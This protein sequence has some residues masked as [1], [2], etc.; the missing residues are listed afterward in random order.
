[1]VGVEV[2]RQP[3]VSG[4]QTGSHADELC[5]H[6]QPS[7]ILQPALKHMSPAQALKEWQQRKPELFQ[8]IFYKQAGLDK[9]PYF[10]NIFTRNFHYKSLS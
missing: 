5:E 2:C 3:T 9:Q 10:L 7:H 8:K 4:A 1:M 6:T